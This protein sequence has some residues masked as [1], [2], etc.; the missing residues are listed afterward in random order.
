VPGSLPP[1]TEA[2]PTPVVT[3]APTDGG[4]LWQ[5]H[6][7]VP[8]GTHLLLVGINMPTGFSLQASSLERLGAT[9]AWEPVRLDR[10]PPPWEHFAVV[11]LPRRQD[12]GHLEPW[13]AGRYRLTVAFDPSSISRTIEIVVSDRTPTP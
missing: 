6:F 12:D 5:D 4:P 8:D 11:G 2:S 10:Y 7:A 3:A 1:A 9:G 13:P